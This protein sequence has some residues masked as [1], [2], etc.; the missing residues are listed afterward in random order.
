[1]S[2][3]SGQSQGNPGLTVAPNSSSNLI[4]TQQP[5][6]TIQNSNQ[7]QTA[8]QQ[9][10]QA[11]GLPQQLNVDNV[12]FN[13]ADN[14]LFQTSGLMQMSQDQLLRLMQQPLNLQQMNQMVQNFNNLTN[15][16]LNQQLRTNANLATAG[17]P[18]GVSSGPPAM[19]GLPA[20]NANVI[21]HGQISGINFPQ[22]P[23]QLF[24]INLGLFNVISPQQMGGI[25][26]IGA[27]VFQPIT[28]L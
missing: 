3:N 18:N 14:N 21:G 16:N 2:V 28:W 9:Q 15:A 20:P 17:G 4:V 8:P 12:N 25:G 26:Q 7:I 23:Q 1:M 27:Q 5:Q 13:A 22:N 10:N 19:V 6:Q 11:P 24:G